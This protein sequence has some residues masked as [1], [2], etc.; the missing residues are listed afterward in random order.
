MGIVLVFWYIKTGMEQEFLNYWAKLDPKVKFELYAEF[1]CEPVLQSEIEGFNVID[2]SSK[3]DACTVF[4]NV[5]IWKDEHSFGTFIKPNENRALE[6]FEVQLPT[7]SVLKRKNQH[8]G[9]W[10]GDWR[11]T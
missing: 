2:F 8:M 11:P 6:P 1:L 9:E 4:V 10:S 7:R 3:H 5:A